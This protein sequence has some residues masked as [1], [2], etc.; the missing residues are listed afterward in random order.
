MT[1]MP[2]TL[3]WETY[4][5]LNDASPQ[6]Q[7]A[8]FYPYASLPAVERD[9]WETAG[10]AA[11]AAYKAADTYP[12]GLGISCDNCHHVERGDFVVNDHDTMEDRLTLI[13]EHARTKRGWSIGPAGDFCHACATITATPTPE[14]QP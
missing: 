5:A 4:M 8:G 7:T 1:D 10:R 3:G 6:R 9:A 2:H 12:C 13:R 14:N 11:V